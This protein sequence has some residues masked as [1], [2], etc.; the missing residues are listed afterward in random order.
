M[1]AARLLIALLPWFADAQQAQPPS[2][3]STAQGAAPAS[4]AAVADFD[5]RPWISD[6]HEIR[7]ALSEKYANFE[8]AV[9]ERELD[10]SDLFARTET[11]LGNATKRRRCHVACRWRPGFAGVAAAEAPGRRTWRRVLPRQGHARKRFAEPDSQIS[12]RPTPP[13]AG[14]TRVDK[15]CVSV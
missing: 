9:F 5:T 11:R 6:L 1:A 15:Q 4:R 2:P 13:G 7:A 3:S 8:W 14:H 10:L 12:R